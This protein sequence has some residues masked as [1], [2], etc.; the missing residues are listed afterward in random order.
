[1]LSDRQQKNLTA[2]YEQINWLRQQPDGIIF[3]QN[4]GDNCIAIKKVKSL[5]LLLLADQK[6][7][8][9]NVAQSILDLNN[10][11][12]LIFPYARAMLLALIWNSQ[13]KKIYAI[14]FGGGSIPRFFH[15]YFAGA[16]IECTDIDATV[17]EVAQ[18]FFG[19][20][21]DHRLKVAIQDG[22]EYLAQQISTAKYDI[23]IVDA[24]FGSG[25]MPYSLVTQE[26]YKLCKECLSSTGVA[27]VH[28]FHKQE[29]NAAV[30]KTIQS[31]FAQVYL[32]N[33]ETGNSIVIATNASY[34]DRNEIFLKAEVI[35]DFY[36]LGFSLVE[37]SFQLKN[38]AELGE[39][40]KNW[41]ALPIF[42]DAE[43]PAG[44]LDC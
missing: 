18:K 13:P 10:P 16:T 26:F 33:L 38:V 29:F 15:H 30:V 24:G 11:L 12:S 27:V 40:V 8:S 19:I 9:T 37:Q 34:I 28:L 23:I 35:Q 14:G 17:V 41:E 2:I 43:M 44:Y 31:V 4:S 7:L 20:Q 3:Q 5:L 36:N 1:M 21:L 25:Y 22:R 42:R 32:C 6:T 39:W